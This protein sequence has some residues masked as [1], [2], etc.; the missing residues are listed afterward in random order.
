MKKEELNQ[1][2]QELEE[3]IKNHRKDHKLDEEPI[4]WSKMLKEPVELEAI[5]NYWKNKL[6]D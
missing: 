1:K 2:I 5:L 6:N 4:T 3:Y